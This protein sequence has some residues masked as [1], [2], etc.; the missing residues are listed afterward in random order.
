MSI[1]KPY[2][3]FLT[4]RRGAALAIVRSDLVFSN[5]KYIED[6]FDFIAKQPVHTFVL[7]N[8]TSDQCECIELNQDV[9]FARVLGKTA[10]N[11][12]D[13]YLHCLTQ[14]NLK[15]SEI[16]TLIVGVGP[17]SFT[18]LRLGCAFANGLHLGHPVSLLPLATKLVS[19]MLALTSNMKFESLFKNQLGEYDVEDESTGYITFFDLMQALFQ[20][21]AMQE[22]FFVESLLPNY[23]KDP[24]PLAKLKGT[25]L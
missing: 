8:S 24:G 9:F 18:G 11:L 20:M 5:F 25:I 1:N 2:A 23:A 22:K 12:C 3:L 6:Y 15:N 16:E 10:E 4:H 14:M 19:D 7:Q 21:S 13:L 17:G